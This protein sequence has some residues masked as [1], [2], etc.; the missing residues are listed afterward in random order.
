MTAGEH[1]MPLHLV[2]Y[3]D[4]LS[5]PA[6]ATGDG[7]RLT[8]TPG[9]DVDQHL[10]PGPGQGITAPEAQ[11]A[12]FG[13]ARLTVPDSAARDLDVAPPRRT[14]AIQADGHVDPAAAA[15]WHQAQT[16]LVGLI[17][18]E[19]RASVDQPDADRAAVL[20]DSLADWMENRV[21]ELEQSEPGIG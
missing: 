4:S 21:T 14:A 15:R 1:E 13:A 20:P 3:V 19:S 12:A 5:A 10:A 17:Q 18:E 16:E 8:I 2:R 9:T 11:G 6:A 7:S